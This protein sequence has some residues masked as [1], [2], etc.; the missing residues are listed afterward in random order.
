MEKLAFTFFL[1]LANMGCDGGL[2]LGS[3][4]DASTKLEQSTRSLQDKR[5]LSRN[6]AEAKQ[7]LAE[8][9][10]KNDTD[11]IR[12]GL[13]K[14]LS[15]ELK[16]DI[17][18]TIAEEK[19]TGLLP[20]LVTALQFNSGCMSGGS[21]SEAAQKQLNE[22][23]VK[24]IS[25]LTSLSFPYF[26]ASKIPVCSNDSPSWEIRRIVAET[27]EWISRNVDVTEHVLQ[28]PIR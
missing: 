12:E 28:K 18:A 10:K 5:I 21:E 1:V 20:D 6:Y 27:N 23:V 13:L 16:G 26:D 24:A 3:L 2:R 19:M 7:A 15:F 9:V 14:S 4:K 25:S 22:K 8:A 17:A 11:T